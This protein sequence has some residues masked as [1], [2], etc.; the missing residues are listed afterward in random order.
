MQQLQCRLLLD[1]VVG[2]RTGV[3][4]LLA[5]EDESLL[6]RQDILLVLNLLRHHLD[7]VGRFNL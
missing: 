4:E 6:V 7:H 3:L 2:K 5:R 1:V